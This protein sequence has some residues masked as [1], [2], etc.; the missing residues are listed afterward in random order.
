MKTRHLEHSHTFKAS[1]SVTDEY[2]NIVSALGA[3]HTVELTKSAGKLSTTELTIA[4]SGNATSTAEFTFTSQASGTG[5][6]TVK[7]KTKAG[8]IY[9][10]AE[11]KLHY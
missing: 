10:E 7:A 9:T 5:T 3:G 6:D 2:G 1:V 4:S 8:T 11:A